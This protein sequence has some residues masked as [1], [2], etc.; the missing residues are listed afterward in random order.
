MSLEK[1]YG[2]LED[3]AQGGMAKILKG[4]DL[5][6][7]R[8]VAIKR[9]LPSED[10]ERFWQEARAT[11][12]LEHANIPPLYEAGRDEQGQP[13]LALKLVR[14]H[15][16]T[17]L[18]EK[19]DQ[20]ELHD[21]YRFPHRLAVFEKVCEAVAYAHQQGVFHRD[22]KPDNIMV[23]EYG[24][25]FLLDWGLARGE[26]AAPQ[27]DAD[28]SGTPAYCAPEIVRGE[29]PSPASEVYSLGATLYEWM[30]LRPAHTGKN[31]VDVLNSV[32]K[33]GPADPARLAHKAQDKVPIEVARV[34]LQAMAKDPQNRY[35]SV[36]ELRAAVRNILDGEIKPVCPCTTVKFS[37]R[38]ITTAIDNYPILSALVLL[39]MIYP[40]LHWTYLGWNWY[41]V[42]PG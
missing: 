40:L 16:L 34:I 30:S 20:G 39:W 7:G 12:R 22:I 23:G 26:P 19:L 18:I 27:P 33:H 28:F 5:S 10:P 41:R 29:G 1:R 4:K 35:A 24:E 14:G 9:P 42:P 17:Q 8:E 32:M 31:L 11:G 2:D 25:V 3:L 15:S 38:E 21:L 37:F 13:Y 6:L 36:A